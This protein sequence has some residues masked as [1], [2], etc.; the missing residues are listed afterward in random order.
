MWGGGP[1][2]V[3]LDYGG[4]KLREMCWKVEKS[5]GWKV[6]SSFL[7]R[8]GTQSFGAVQT[9]W[10]IKQNRQGNS[11]AIFRKT[12]GGGGG[13]RIRFAITSCEITAKTTLVLS[14]TRKHTLTHLYSKTRQ[15]DGFLENK[16]WNKRH[17]HFNFLHT[18]CKK[19]HYRTQVHNTFLK[20]KN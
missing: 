16:D 13:G 3:I 9:Q 8:V 1:E 6:G 10:K 14:F 5:T 19:E 15:R 17:K 18:Q 4:R 2:V 12:D 20:N 11:N 7:G